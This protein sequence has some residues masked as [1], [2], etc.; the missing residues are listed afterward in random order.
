[1]NIACLLFSCD[2]QEVSRET[3]MRLLTLVFNELYPHVTKTG[4][5]Q[6]KSFAINSGGQTNILIKLLS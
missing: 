2:K 1:M 5:H 6:E 4:I 3:M